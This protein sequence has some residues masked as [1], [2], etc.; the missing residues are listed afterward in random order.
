M[1]NSAVKLLYLLIL[2]SSFIFLTWSNLFGQNLEITEIEFRGGASFSEDELSDLLH[3]ERG[4]EFDVR[5][6]KLDKIVLTNFYRK[7]GY[8]T[9]SVF[10]SLTIDKITQSV[11]ILYEFC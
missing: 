10:D 1:M 8:L 5:L 3:S 2:L 9:V 4:D 11:K 7:N 6:V